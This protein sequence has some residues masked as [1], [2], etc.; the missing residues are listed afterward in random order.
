MDGVSFCI[1]PRTAEWQHG[2][3]CTCINSI[4]V[5]WRV[6]REVVKKT[7]SISSSAMKSHIFYGDWSFW[8]ATYSNLLLSSYS[9]KTII[10]SNKK[11]GNGYGHLWDLWLLSNI[12]KITSTVWKKRK[13]LDIDCCSSHVGKDSPLMCLQILLAAKEFLYDFTPFRDWNQGHIFPETQIAQH[14]CS[15]PCVVCKLLLLSGG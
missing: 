14:L 15:W 4:G 12:V 7:V 5:Q 2:S 9:N 3:P 8:F 6:D 13:Q 10:C 11:W 1:S